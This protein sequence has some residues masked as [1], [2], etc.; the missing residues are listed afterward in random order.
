MKPVAGVTGRKA[1]AR[2][3]SCELKDSPTDGLLFFLCMSSQSIALQSQE[4][5]SAFSRQSLSPGLCD[6]CPWLR[7]DSLR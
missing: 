6:F 5:A 2:E 4:P 3:F 1:S 7:E